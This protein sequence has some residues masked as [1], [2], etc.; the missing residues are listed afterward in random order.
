MLDCDEGGGV[1]RAAF[2]DGRVRSRGYGMTSSQQPNQQQ[3]GQAAQQF[4]VHRGYQTV[5]TQQQATSQADQQPNTLAAHGGLIGTVLAPALRLVDEVQAAAQYDNKLPAEVKTLTEG[6]STRSAPAFQPANYDGY[7][8]AALHQMVTQGVDPG[9]V[10][11]VGDT[12]L[13]MG[14][15]LTQ[16]QN[17][18][19]AALASSETTWQGTAGDNARRS[20]AELGN[21]GAAA[22]QAAQLAGVVTHQQ[23][24]AS[25][26]ARNSMPP[27]PNPPFNPAAASQ[28]LRTITD[29]IA[30]AAQAAADQQAFVQQKQAQ[31]QAAHIVREYDT[32]LAQTSHTMPAFAPA[33]SPVK[34]ASGATPSPAQTPT[35][36]G[37]SRNSSGLGPPVSP[38]QG[39][40]RV[41]QSPG[42][43][44][45]GQMPPSGPTPA[46]SV[47]GSGPGPEQTTTSNA[48]GT[49]PVVSP[50]SG[51]TL[52]VGPADPGSGGNAVD[53]LV[54][55]IV[56]PFGGVGGSANDALRSGSG[57]G[58]GAG[59]PGVGGLSGG[60][61][62]GGGRSGIGSGAAAAEEAAVERAV[63]GPGGM[64]GGMVPAG[65]GGKGSEDSEH[66]RPS[67]LVE[68]DPNELFGVTEK[69]A[70]PVIGEET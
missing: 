43:E 8:H 18:I 46:A 25:A 39:V 4:G 40:S 10:G 60:R 61:G 66:Y 70:P 12:W 47:P 27:P 63:A 26:N 58:H 19:A 24:E 28:Q 55:D 21:K 49:A 16:F 20:V 36:G 44:T 48:T 34:P 3:V 45:T 62:A 68:P 59:G 14:N 33:P 38:S 2:A 35:A 23:S 6:L 65:R 32:T 42:T 53:P 29:P 69:I 67:F 31:Q 51:S 13:E 7:S 64:G 41:P 5:Q 54:A 9:T 52:N 56:G 22:G 15:D 1:G 17:Q 50:G 30:Y 37:S 11:A 57:F